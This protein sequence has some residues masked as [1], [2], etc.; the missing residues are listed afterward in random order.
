MKDHSKQFLKNLIAAISPSGYEEEAARI[1]QAEAKTFAASVKHDAHGNSHAIVNPGGSPRIMFAGHYDEI[2][3]LV[4]HIDDNG[5]LWIQPIGGWDSQIPQ[6]HRV[7]IRGRKGRVPGVIGKKP[8]HLIRPE[9][10]DKVT[11]L[12]SLWV[13]IGVKNRKQA[14]KLVAIGDPLV[15]DHEMGE[16]QGEFLVARGFDNRIGA[17]IVLEAARLLSEMKIKA[18]IHAVATVQ[19]EIGIRGARTA[20]FG[21]DPQVGI[22]VDVTFATDHP[23]MEDAVKRFGRIKLGSGAVITRGP[24]VHPRLFDLLVETADKKKIP[25]QVEAQSG[26][27]G[28]D[29][30]LIQVNRAGVITGLVSVPNRYMHSSC[31][32]IH[33]GDVEAVIR[34]FAETAA[35]IAPDTR[36]AIV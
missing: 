27:T 28:T 8:I 31:E 10:R 3:F 18:E 24:N 30:N 15:L 12:D 29:A 13:D 16:L 7:V 25:Y 26:P 17:F 9:E 32:M 1:W 14:E 2:G 34:L 4:S 33:A 11:K 22:A 19:E 35:R 5:F 21:I 23:T 6:G 36:F 20:A